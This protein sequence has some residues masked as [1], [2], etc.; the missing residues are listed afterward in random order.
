MSTKLDREAAYQK[1]ALVKVLG[2]TFYSPNQYCI[3]QLYDDPT[4]ILE[5]SYFLLLDGFLLTNI[6][7]TERC[8]SVTKLK[9]CLAKKRF[10]LRTASIMTV[11]SFF[12]CWIVHFTTLEN[13]GHKGHWMGTLVQD[14]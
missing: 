7:V 3:A 12:Y 6:N 5:F 14:C 10:Y 4:P 9:C 13:S 1:D 11:V 8:R 2:V